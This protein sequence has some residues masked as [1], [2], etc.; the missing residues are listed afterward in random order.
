VK[1]LADKKKK[2][3]DSGLN[4]SPDLLELLENFKEIELEDFELEAA[5]LELWFESGALPKQLLPQ[6]KAAPAVKGK[7]AELTRAKSLRSNLAPPKVKVE[8]VA[9]P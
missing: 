6:L 1:P 7:P 4:L 2:D 5:D 9:D 3:V 8:R